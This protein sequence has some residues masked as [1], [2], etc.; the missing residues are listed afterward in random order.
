MIDDLEFISRC[1]DYITDPELV[2]NFREESQEILKE[3]E[4]K[5]EYLARLTDAFLTEEDRN[6][7]MIAESETNRAAKDLFST[8]WKMINKTDEPV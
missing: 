3:T 7:I 2:S 8:Y 5:I 1:T 4:K 6:N